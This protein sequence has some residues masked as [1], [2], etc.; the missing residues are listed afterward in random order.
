MA[1]INE[2][3]GKNYQEESASDSIK[4]NVKLIATNIAHHKI[5]FR[6]ESKS[7]WDGLNMNP[8]A[9]DQLCSLT[10]DLNHKLR[11]MYIAKTTKEIAMFPY[12]IDGPVEYFILIDLS[13]A[14]IKLYSLYVTPNLIEAQ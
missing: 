7:I 2:V 5:N 10:R 3:Y 13:D 12:L 11:L 9:I 14:P 8:S 4:S 1:S 6:Y